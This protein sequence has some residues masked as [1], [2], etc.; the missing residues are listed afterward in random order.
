MGSRGAPA[1]RRV[2]SGPR[3]VPVLGV[4][5]G[6][7]PDPL[8]FLSRVAGEHGDVAF[9]R[10]PGLPA[11]LLTGPEEIEEVLVGKSRK[12]AKARIMRK[13]LSVAGEGL[14]VS[15][16][17][18][19]RRQ[20][21]LV[22]P[23]FHGARIR[24]Y[25]GVMVSYADRMLD[26]WV[27]GSARDVHRDLMGLTLEIVVKTLFDQD[28]A[29]EGAAVGEALG[30]I[31]SHFSDQGLASAVLR[32]LPEAVPTPSNLR[33]RRAK[34][35]LAAIVGGLVEERRA[36]SGGGRDLLAMLAEARDEEGR[37][38]GEA[39]I[40]DEA[41]T[42]VLAGHETTAIALSW[43]FW[44]LGGHP[45]AEERLGAEVRGELGDRPAGPEDLP[46]LP[47]A[48]AVLKESMRL[49]PPAWAVGREALEDCEIGGYHVPEGTQ[50][51]IS[52]YLVQRDGRFFEDP[53]AF[54]PERWL[55]GAAEGLPRY[56]Y[57]PFGGGPRMC[58]GS[59]FARMEAALLLATI[60]RRF[61]LAR[62]PGR[63][64]TPRPT[65][66]LR[67]EGG[68]WAVPERRPG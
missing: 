56:A 32:M 54:R 25:A 35:R 60:A 18:F 48:D 21:R 49:Y 1:G 13:M 17:D 5:P 61:R 41:L 51:F 67:P 39:Q 6:Y 58:V 26:G 57:F 40:R 34:E 47:Y 20:R 9:L 11:Y 52:P 55:N 42:V 38:M 43:T 8:S 50:M 64:P 19:W 65:I 37:G 7:S 63:A 68:V 44:L 3:A 12:F 62:V 29:E 30:D 59:G 15:E 27:E 10:F 46:R 31:M 2:P 66:T 16:G 33:H 4:L 28:V 53:E 14:L 45:E 36:G 24:G 23:A 22:A